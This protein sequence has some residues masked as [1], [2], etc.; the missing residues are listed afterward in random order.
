[1]FYPARR[2]PSASD[3]HLRS[4]KD[5]SSSQCRAAER[6]SGQML[7]VRDGWVHSSIK[8]SSAMATYW[9][10]HELFKQR[11]RYTAAKLKR[12][13]FFPVIFRRPLVDQ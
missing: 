5:Q 9:S 12:N 10:D 2:S 11:G 13:H 8:L 3:Y 7:M 6:G 4:R 1:M